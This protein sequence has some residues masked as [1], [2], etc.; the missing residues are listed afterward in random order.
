[1]RNKYPGKC[2]CGRKVKAEEGY[3]QRKEGK[4]QTRCMD[5]VVKGKVAKNYTL[6]EN[7]KIYLTEMQSLAV[8]LIKEESLR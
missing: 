4:W 7:Q 2:S 6:S 8:Y 5:C 1:M 3:I